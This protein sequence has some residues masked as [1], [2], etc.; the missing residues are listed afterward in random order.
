MRAVVRIHKQLEVAE[1]A[2]CRMK[3][4]EIKICP[5]HHHLET[6]IWAPVF[7]WMLAYADA[8]LQA[9]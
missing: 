7:L 8:G 4:P 3:S 2:F 1:R 9:A 5:T 6:L